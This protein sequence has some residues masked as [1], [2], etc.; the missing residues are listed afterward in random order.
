MTNTASPDVYP[1]PHHV[2]RDLAFDVQPGRTINRAWMPVHEYVCNARGRVRTGLVATVV[3]AICGG[4]AVVSASPGWIATA[5]LTVHVTA[6]IV[7]DEV[8]AFARVRRS[9]RTTVVLESEIF[10]DGRNDDPVAI[11][12]ATFTVLQ[13]RD[14]NPIL[15]TEIDGEVPRRP[16]VE[17]SARFDRDA[18]NACG[19]ERIAH[20]T[21]QVSPSPYIMNS[22]GGVQGGI[23]ASLID[24]A[25]INVLGDEFETVDLHLVYL[26]L[27]KQ[28]PIRASAIIND[29][30]DDFG[31]VNVT[32]EDIGAGRVTTRATA[33]GVRW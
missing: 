11:A 24:D 32:V 5:D 28:G 30:H 19:F 18:Y 26:A 15:D 27:A 21:V 14:N 4:L 2:L 31:S 10:V 16:F 13:R 17:H 33:V 3:D 25:T 6:P 7:G 23:L 29:L 12:T 20:D 8:A 1:P 9:G 22:L